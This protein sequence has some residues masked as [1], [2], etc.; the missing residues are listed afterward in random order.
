MTLSSLFSQTVGSLWQRPLTA[1][2]PQRPHGFPDVDKAPPDVRRMI[3]DRRYCRVLT[4]DADV[5][6]DQ[7]SLHCAWKALEHEMALVPAG[8]VSLVSNRAVAT[9]WGFD[10]STDQFHK[11]GVKSI[12]LDRYQVSNFDYARFVAAGGYSNW[13]LWPDDVLPTVLQFLDQSGRPGPRF[14]SEG[15][16]PA[17]KE[18]HPVVGICWYEANAYATWAAKRLPTSA[19][20]QRS[21]TWTKSSSENGRELRFPWG[22]AF[23]PQRANTRAARRG[24]TVPVDG[25]RDGRTLNG[26]QQLIGNVWEWVDSQFQQESDDDVC[27]LID[28]PMAEIRGGAFDTYFPSQAT[29]QFR[30]GQPLLHRGAN[31]GFRCCVSVE[32]LPQPPDPASLS[33]HEAQR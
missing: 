11:V 20:W 27:V 13:D 29:C 26:V 14:W 31:V 9:G 3:R 15:R 25:F 5:P 32:S 22:N 17:G 28:Q 19:E 18:H 6:F 16:P 24:D 1:A 2:P 30:S 10:F 21:G 33:Q 4:A 7:D 23:D 12:Y 8:P